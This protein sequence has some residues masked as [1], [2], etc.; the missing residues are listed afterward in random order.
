MTDQT[1]KIAASTYGVARIET[2]KQIFG[3][4]KISV[5]LSASFGSEGGWGYSAAV[6]WGM[7]PTSLK[8]REWAKTHSVPFYYAETGFIGYE[9]HPALDKRM[10]SLALD[11]LGAYYDYSQESRL[12]RLV[13]THEE[14]FTRDIELKAL[15]YRDVLRSYGITK[16]NDAQKLMS[17]ELFSQLVLDSNNVMVIDQAHGDLS[18]QYSGAKNDAFESMLDAAIEE[19]PESTV[20][21]K[22]HPDVKHGKAKSSIKHL[23]EA[24]GVAVIEDNISSSSLL[25]FFDKVYTV[26]SSMGFEALMREC[27]VV[28]FG[29]PFYA[30][31]GFTDDRG[32]R[33]ERR[34][35]VANLSLN[36][37]FAAAYMR[38]C[39]YIDPTTNKICSFENTLARLVLKS[40]KP[41]LSAKHIYVEAFSA[42]KRGFIKRYLSALCPDT[43]VTFIKDRNALS[44]LEA[45]E[46]LMVWGTREV[47]LELTMPKGVQVWAVEDGFIRS[48]GLGSDL[49]VPSSLAIDD[50][51]MHYDV[52]G[53]SRLEQILIENQ[54][55]SFEI[56]YARELIKRICSNRIA[57]YNVGNAKALKYKVEAKDKKLI[58]VAGQVEDDQSIKLSASS[59]KT[60][61]ELLMRVREDNPDAYIVYKTHPDIVSGNRKSEMRKGDLSDY[62]NAI[63]TTATISDCLDHFDEVHVVSSLAGFEALLRGKTVCCYGTPFYS[64]WGLTHDRGFSP[65]WRTRQLTIEELVL[66]ALAVYPTYYDWRKNALT[67]VDGILESWGKVEPKELNKSASFLRKM[68]NLLSA[69]A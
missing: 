54:Y 8:L 50:L 25:P 51:G 16:Y 3:T 56:D 42:W 62:C 58:L 13:K 40:R 22:L 33:C 15:K 39:T 6:G 55:E 34:N 57:K 65:L 67:D 32:V 53:G 20:Y 41:S 60:N 18:L 46:V 35:G 37:L 61:I 44:T 45:G 19:N 5:P 68:K 30:G 11:D 47:A 31:W 36:T 59:I 27:Q 12:E 23:A 43:R 29:M 14:W 38:Y 49:S 66:G 9:T 69:K 21:V 26:S 63:E 10:I 28:C 64:G 7:K 2:L 4:N 48:V 17:D 52:F 1:S 24:R